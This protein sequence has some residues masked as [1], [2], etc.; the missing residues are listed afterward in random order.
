FM[1]RIVFDGVFDRHPDLK[2][3]THHGGGMTPHFAGRIGG[4]MDQLGARTPED[5]RADVETSIKGR[6]YDYFK[7]FYVDTAMMDAP[8]ALDCVIDFYG[9]DHVLFASDSPF[10][11]EKGPGYIRATIANIEE[12]DISDDDRQA[13]YEGN[14]RRLLALPAAV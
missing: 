9:V 12:I 7:K 1:S 8:H 10:D 13:I 6:P 14:A 5:Q 11:P 3:L 4:G 2:I